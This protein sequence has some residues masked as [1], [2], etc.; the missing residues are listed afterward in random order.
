MSIR[1]ITS[2]YSPFLKTQNF[3]AI[4]DARAQIKNNEFTK[5]TKEKF[6]GEVEALLKK[7]E[8][9]PHMNVSEKFGDEIDGW[10]AYSPVRKGTSVLY[11]MYDEGYEVKV[12]GDDNPHNDSYS[13]SAEKMLKSAKTNLQASI[14]VI[15]S[16][17]R[18]SADEK[19]KRSN[20]YLKAAIGNL[21]KARGFFQKAQKSFTDFEKRAKNSYD[22]EQLVAA[23][24]IR[25]HVD[26][27][28]KETR[29]ENNS[30]QNE[31][32]NKGILK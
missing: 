3:I 6:L 17:N 27:I 18:L 8:D 9:R 32:R 28:V 1:V 19:Q 26:D 23:I 21:D 30:L 14:K 31:M 13:Q 2:N 16:N 5:A 10:L 22:K 29:G 7:S 24:L 4:I 20:N 15:E 11:W 25:Q 12:T